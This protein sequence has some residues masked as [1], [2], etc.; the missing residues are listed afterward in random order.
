MVER[1]AVG[2]GSML[3]EGLSGAVAP[4]SYGTG[5]VCQE[6]A[7]EVRLSRYNSTDWCALHESPGATGRPYDASVRPRGRRRNSSRRR[8]AQR[9]AA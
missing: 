3:A 2:D 6:P 1:R 9:T 5:R 7:C 8:N 4:V